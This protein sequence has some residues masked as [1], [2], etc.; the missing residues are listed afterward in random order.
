ME[1]SFDQVKKKKSIQEICVYSHQKHF[2]KNTNASL[3]WAVP[4]LV[5]HLK[6]FFLQLCDIQHNTHQS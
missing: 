3:G 1:Q 2:E 4:F 5:S 6:E